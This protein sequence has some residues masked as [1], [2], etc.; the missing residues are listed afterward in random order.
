MD[1]QCVTTDSIGRDMGIYLHIPF[2]RHKCA[3]C[4][5]AAYEGLQAYYDEYVEALCHEIELW[6]EQYPECTKIPVDTIYFGGGTPTQLSLEQLGKILS[7]VSQYF[8]WKPNIEATIEANPGEL[9]L[10]YVKGLRELGYNRISYGVQC[11]DDAL[12]ELLR[13]GH[14]AEEAHRAVYE[15]VEAGFKNINID[16]IYSLPG[17]SVEEIR[18]Q[19]RTAVALPITH[20]SIYGLQLEPGTNLHAQVEQGRICLPDEDAA[21]SMYDC[22]LDTLAEVGFERYEISN[23]T[24]C[25]AYSRH[26]LRYWQYKDY[27]GFGAGAH[28]FYKGVRR[29]NEGYVVPYV[30]RL[31]NHRLPLIEEVAI[32]E[33]RAMGDFCFLALR[34]K[35]G[36]CATTFEETF[37]RSLED[38]YGEILERLTR[39]QLL[40]Q[41]DDSWHLTRLG[42]KYGNHVFAEFI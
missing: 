38:T 19:V 34:T 13:R 30:N 6:V 32:D 9:S 27:L 5:F 23:F 31:R 39:Q 18:R 20:I 33:A 12:L 16:L 21:E 25:G 2:C 26:N 7:A 17:Q 22:M 24:N 4:D 42:A 40:E 41:R 28:S 3:Y 1:T 15:A 36:L 29:E 14:T 10:E 11:F 37:H 35:W 8:T